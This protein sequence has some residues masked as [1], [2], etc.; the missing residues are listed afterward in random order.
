MPFEKAGTINVPV[1]SISTGHGAHA[2]SRASVVRLLSVFLALTVAYVVYVHQALTSFPGRSIPPYA[3]RILAECDAMVALPGPPPGFANRATSDRFVSGTPPTLITNATIWTGGNDGHE[4]LQNGNILL[5]QGLVKFV[6]LD[7]PK[8]L[9]KSLPKNLQVVNAEEAWVTP[10][11]VDLH[12]HA[13]VESL[14]GFE[15]SS[16]GNSM[17]GIAQPWL[18][19]VDAIDTRTLSST[20]AS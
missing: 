8:Y 17:L 13:G 9:L 1:A 7:V 18:R 5:D 6:G 19:S 15:G 11:I 14:P 10:A 16:D 3:S 4:L 2:R 12:N 20:L